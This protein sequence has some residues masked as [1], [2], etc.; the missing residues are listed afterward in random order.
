MKNSLWDS[1]R[2]LS[3]GAAVCLH[4]KKYSNKPMCLNE[5]NV[6]IISI[7]QTHRLGEE[8]EKHLLP[9]KNS[10]TSKIIF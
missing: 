1:D 9:N 3:R 6:S 8:R 4:H 5:C 7:T 2:V 10:L